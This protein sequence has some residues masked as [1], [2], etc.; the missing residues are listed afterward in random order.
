MTGAICRAAGLAVHSYT[1]PHLVRFNERISVAGAPIDD[2]LLADTLAECE[3]VNRGNPITFFEITTA[4]AYLAFARTPADV[5]LVETGLG[6][7]LDAT[8]LF[9]APAVTAITPVSR[10]HVQFLGDNIGAIAAEKAGILKAGVAAVIGP[11]PPE[12]MAAIAA[13][14]DEIGAR[15][16]CWD[17]DWRA[18]A[19]ANGIAYRDGGIELA[20]PRPALEGAHQIVN[21]GIAVACARRLGIAAIDGAALASG[22]ADVRWPGRLQHLT[23]G[24]LASTLGAGWQLWLDGGHN[25]A[26]ARALAA[27][28]ADAAAWR[29]G[30]LYLVF[31]TLTA[32]D[33]EMFLKPLAGHVAGLRAVRIPATENGMTAADAAH[34]AR[35]AGIESKPSDDVAAALA[36][37]KATAP[38]PGRVLIC[39]SLYLAGHVLAENG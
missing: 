14:G 1:S 18:D 36:D 21:A 17:T 16:V 8:N 23:Q 31:G 5:V 32:R 24:R 2:R 35:R 27:T 4:A 39:G 20:L 13:R 7:R 30:P 3:T 6:G 19:V 15:L 29:T 22:L 10:D 34:A 38:E 26:A 11:Q 37:I 33:P 25:E 28:I 12:A 9:P